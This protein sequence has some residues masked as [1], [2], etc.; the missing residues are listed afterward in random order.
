MP[1]RTGTKQ[2]QRKRKPLVVTVGGNSVRIYRRPARG[3]RAP[4]WQV[5][6][7]ASGKR[8]LLSFLSEAEAKAEAARIAARLNQQDRAGAAMTGDDARDLVRAQ[9]ALD[10]IAMD[11]PS[12]CSLL[13]DLWR[14]AGGRNNLVLAV[15]DYAKRHLAA[16]LPVARA[17]SDVLASKESKGR[18]DR[19][20]SD[21]R[22]RLS[23]F[24]EHFAGRNLGD[25]TTADVQAWIDGLR[26]ADGQPLAAQSRRNF[27]TVTSG[28]FEF[29][30]RRGAILANPCRDLER[31]KVRREEVAFWTPKEC[32][33]I[34]AHLD[35]VAL[36]AF[37]VSLFAGC[38]TAEAVRLTWADVNLDAG[39]VVVGGAV[40]KTA[41][42]RLAPLPDN[43]R[44]WLRPL[45][46]SPDAPL[47][48]SDGVALARAVTAACA[49]ASVRRLAN[50]ARHSCI[51]FKVALSG[52]VA[53][54]ALESGNSP[55]VVHAHYRGLATTDDAKAFFSIMPPTRESGVRLVA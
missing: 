44:A 14:E 25:L 28:C 22:H 18:S 26:S 55:A 43:A 34:L 41:S 4:S 37:L 19:L 47:F 1:A 40:A 5:A 24:A 31:E 11:V 38:R 42:R 12:A 35:P 2:K 8:V 39:H 17:V 9:D 30:R 49:A 50:G 23:K 36:P 33:A 32:A 16:P 53:R 45:V 20:L 21:Y 48:P 54:V 51:T 52:D 6:S 46:G 10:G 29:H 27:A 15:R 3:T 7:Y 13:A